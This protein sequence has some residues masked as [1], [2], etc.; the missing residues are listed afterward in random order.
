MFIALTNNYPITSKQGRRNGHRVQTTTT[1]V[2]DCSP[3]R[4]SPDE[5][6]TV[7]GDARR[8]QVTNRNGRGVS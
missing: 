6:P 1:T 4:G 3:V 2:V 5:R 7:S 8:W